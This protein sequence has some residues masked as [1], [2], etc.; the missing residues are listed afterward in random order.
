[1][2]NL[3]N[4]DLDMA[5]ELFALQLLND[6]ETAHIEADEILLKLLELAGY[7]ESVSA[8]RELRQ[9]HNYGKQ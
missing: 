6:P 2:N 7:N 9:W 8:Y 4:L 3:P 1:M 5:N